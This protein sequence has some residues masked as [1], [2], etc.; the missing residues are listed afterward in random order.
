M[1]RIIRK[2][3]APGDRKFIVTCEPCDSQI[4]FKASEATHSSENPTVETWTI[5]C[6]VCG[7]PL[8]GNHNNA[9]PDP[10]IYEYPIFDGKMKTS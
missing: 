6:P 10:I 8:I 1:S 2:G 4:E 3:R 7:S 9:A 5:D